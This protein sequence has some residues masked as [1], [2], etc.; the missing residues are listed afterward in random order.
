V[1]TGTV[2]SSLYVH[3]PGRRGFPFYNG[4]I[5]RKFDSMAKATK[6]KPDGDKCPKEASNLFHNIKGMGKS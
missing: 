1:E 5:I 6:T 4:S 3:E 2:A